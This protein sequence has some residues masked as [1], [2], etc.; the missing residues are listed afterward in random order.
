MNCSKVSVD[1]ECEDGDI[2]NS[3]C[4]SLLLAEGDSPRAGRLAEG[5]AVAVAVRSAVSEAAVIVAEDMK[6]VVVVVE[7]VLEVVVSA[8]GKVA[9]VH[10]A[11]ADADEDGESFFRRRRRSISCETTLSFA[12]ESD[13]VPVGKCNRFLTTDGDN[14]DD[15]GEEEFDVRK[16]PFFEA[17]L[18]VNSTFMG[19]L[20]S[21]RMEGLLCRSFGYEDLSLAFPSS[22][23]QTALL[24]MGTAADGLMVLETIFIL[25]YFVLRKRA[26]PEGAG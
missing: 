10:I 19:L 2:S 13:R 3:C 16:A 4:W 20:L 24:D 25:L 22:A 1:K 26:C 17:A 7:V 21:D 11:I 8:E 5:D 18:V 15:N 12:R 14:E 9:A 23:C 6:A